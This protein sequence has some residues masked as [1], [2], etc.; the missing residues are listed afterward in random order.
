VKFDD[1]MRVFAIYEAKKI[2]N[3][4]LETLR[5]F[6]VLSGGKARE[7]MRIPGAEK[8]DIAAVAE[9]RQR[10]VPL[11][12]I[13]GRAA[14]MGKSFY[15]TSDTLIPRPET[16]LLVRTA[17]DF[18]QKRKEGG[19]DA[20]MVIEIGT[21]C[22]NIAVSLALLCDRAVKIMASDI[23][24][25]AVEIAR[26]NV[27]KFDVDEKVELFCGDLF[28]PFGDHQG[29]VDMVICNPPYIPTSS[30][31]KLAPE[32]IDHEPVVALDGGAYGINIFRRLIDES[33][34]ILKKNGVLLFEIGEG[35]ERM[36]ERLFSKRNTFKNIEYFKYE[37]KVRVVGATRH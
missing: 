8:V 5:L 23:S 4:L 1:F 18:I 12:L 9:M 17:G 14:F 27:H 3:P 6:D 35:Q 11:E 13:L 22:G 31:K 33:S 32:I 37:E 25:E 34:T 26:R 28:Q 21:G 2:E 19:A 10:G 36:I 29:N 16:S 7:V 24:P 15:C 20:Q 30:L